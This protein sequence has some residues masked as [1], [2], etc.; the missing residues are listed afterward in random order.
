M[1]A[2]LAMSSSLLIA[3]LVKQ[4]SV[5]MVLT[6]RMENQLSMVDL[7]LRVVVRLLL[8]KHSLVMHKQIYLQLLLFLLLMDL[9]LVTMLN[10]YLMVV[11]LHLIRTDSQKILVKSD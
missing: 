1:V 11:Q 4:S 6:V 10:L 5:M 9:R 3:S 8:L 2:H 7:N